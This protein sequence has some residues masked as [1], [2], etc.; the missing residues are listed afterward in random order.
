MS[1]T[2]Q[3]KRLPR[4]GRAMPLTVRVEDLTKIYGKGQ[5]QVVALDDVSIT[6]TASKFTTVMGPSGSGKSTLLHCAA[7][8]D[9]PT[10]GKIFFGES[11][12]SRL[13]DS[14][15]TRL[16]R[17]RI[18][19]IFQSYNL[20]PTLNVKENIELPL[21][22][23]NRKE[24]KD[25]FEVVVG[26]MELTPWLNMMPI[27]LSGGQRQRVAW[28]RALITKPDII[29]A[30]EPT[31][32][33]DSV[34][35]GEMLEFLRRGVDR[36]GQ[37]VVQVTHDSFAASFSDRVVF[38]SDGR[39]VADV[40]QPSEEDILL[41]I[42]NLSE[43]GMFQEV[44]PKALEEKRSKTQAPPEPEA[45]PKETQQSAQPK[46]Q[47]P[48][49]AD[50][51]FARPAVETEEEI[52]F[53]PQVPDTPKQRESR[54]AELTSPKAPV[55]TRSADRPVVHEADSRTAPRP[56][57]Q[58][59][60]RREERNEKLSEIAAEL[61]R[62]SHTGQQPPVR[63]DMTLEDARAAEATQRR[64]PQDSATPQRTRGAA[65][66]STTTGTLPS[67]H[68]RTPMGTA[69]TK[70]APTTEP[71]LRPGMGTAPKFPPSRPPL[72]T[73]QQPADRPSTSPRPHSA[74]PQSTDPFEPR[75]SRPTQAPRTTRPTPSAD[76]PFTTP[77][78]PAAP[79]APTESAYDRILR[80][81]GL[82]NKPNSGAPATPPP[83]PATP[84][85]TSTQ[86]A[87]GTPHTTTP[88]PGSGGYV[89]KID[90]PTPPSQRPHPTTASRPVPPTS[91]QGSSTPS[92]SPPSQHHTSPN[93][94][95][96]G[97]PPMDFS[98]ESLTGRRDSAEPRRTTPPARL[99]PPA[100]SDGSR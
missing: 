26:V 52:S 53:E 96:T 37:T 49:R 31:G 13:S 63:P 70:P 22:I 5:A 4:T 100:T 20:V 25:W 9:V 21:L 93:T 51:P 24:D 76:I 35:S 41:T 97:V 14:Q 65:P 88:Y 69:P 85:S 8:L 42:A 73:T 11:D 46:P 1:S 40:D 47:Q 99:N 60:G 86:Y 23:G 2:A 84:Q 77:P 61:F 75:A 66:D 95:P 90:W 59:T 81:L 56:K 45:R 80:E 68:G 36:L 6:F 7:G 17:E 67:V 44:L 72:R 38:L 89:P 10:F 39:V 30:D 16:R 92:W 62:G 91:T 48:Q 27:E 87:A 78:R 28:A 55:Q 43:A 18:G 12:I 50:S 54:R 71:T 82:D 79:T 58:P 32:N 19:F 64:R 29:F 3:E 83:R 98:P 94:T 74:A 57:P 34:S 33:L 15:M